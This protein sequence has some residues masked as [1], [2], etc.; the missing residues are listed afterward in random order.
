MFDIKIIKDQ[1]LE[2]VNNYRFKKNKKILTYNSKIEEIAKNHSINMCNKK[3]KVNHT[4]FKDRLTKISNYNIEPSKHSCENIIVIQPLTEVS[5]AK[6]SL[7]EWIKSKKHR[8]ALVSKTTLTGIGI[9]SLINN[10]K[11]ILFITQIFC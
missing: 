5:C 3:I 9:S 4:G 7:Q 10:N 1:I 6:R 8:N 11:E 2:L